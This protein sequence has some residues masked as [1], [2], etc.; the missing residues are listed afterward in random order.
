MK[1]PVY[2]EGVPMAIQL[3]F[4]IEGVATEDDAIHIRMY[5]PD[6]KRTDYHRR[7]T[8]VHNGEN[9]VILKTPIVPEK[10]LIAEIKKQHGNFKFEL[11]DISAEPIIKMPG[12][13]AEWMRYAEHIAANISDMNTGTYTTD[14]GIKFVLADN[15]KDDKGNALKTPARVYHDNG[16]TEINVNEFAKYSV[17]VRMFILM[18]ERAHYIM[19]TKSEIEADKYAANVLLKNGYPKLEI[20]YAATKI[21]PPDSPEMQ[22]RADSLINYI[23]Q[24][25][26]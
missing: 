23:N 9:C 17:F 22:R 18:H 5:D 14:D 10:N 24:Q 19:N 15:I 4:M 1:F 3:C 11:T 25:A 20:V 8:P 16:D 2:T 12:N 6:K 7:R 26:A 13:D 21:F